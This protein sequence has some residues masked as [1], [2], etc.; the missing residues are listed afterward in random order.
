MSNPIAGI[1]EANHKRYDFIHD[2]G[3]GW[4]KV[5]L[6]D[7]PADFKPTSYSFY[8]ATF[9]YLEE[10]CDA[11]EFWKRHPNITFNEVSVSNFNRNR[12]RFQGGDDD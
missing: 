1:N 6:A 5:P 8:D 12:P 4:L 2:P 9:A 3:H 7:L 10:D 11:P